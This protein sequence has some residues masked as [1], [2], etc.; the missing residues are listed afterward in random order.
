METTHTIRFADSTGLDIWTDIPANS[1]DLVVTSP[2][3]PMVAMW[4]DFFEENA[5]GFKEA[6]AR[7]AGEWMWRSAHN[8]LN[9]VWSSVFGV[10]RP[11]GFICINMGDAVRTIDNEFGY[12]PNHAKTFDQLS[13]IAM[14]RTLPPILW[15]KPTNAPNK[16]MGSGMLPPGAYVTAE[17]EYILIFR[18]Y[19]KRKFDSPESKEI[20]RQSAYFW[21]ERNTWFSDTWKVPGASQ[22]G[23][24]RR[25]A[26]YPTDI[27]LR[28]ISMFSILGD[29]VLDP[30]LGTG[31]TSWAAMATGRNS[32]GIEIDPAVVDTPHNI[33][34]L[35]RWRL[36]RIDRH[37]EFV[38]GHT[39]ELKY[40]HPTY[41]KVKTKQE[42]GILIP[43]VV[44]QQYRPLKN[45]REYTVR[46]DLGQLRSGKHSS[47]RCPSL[48]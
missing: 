18:K 45:G 4:D 37:A 48:G 40:E 13:S 46:Y 3:Y 44:D 41:G 27:P 10:V 36:I 34:L 8:Y 47:C 35:D 2:P 31:T 22:Q 19:D 25:T 39:G 21:E 28:L 26:E 17:H 15:H 23:R 1:V 29:T 7:G 20:R 16:F 9:R 32:I 11:G 43:R 6:K 42:V 12:Y 5:S 30:F 33:P 14:M 38:R 24:T